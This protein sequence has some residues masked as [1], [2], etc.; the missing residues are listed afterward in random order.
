LNGA[1]RAEAELVK[2]RKVIEVQRDV[3][4]LPG[5]LLDPRRADESTER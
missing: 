1:P 5:Q 2:A 3:S 4:A